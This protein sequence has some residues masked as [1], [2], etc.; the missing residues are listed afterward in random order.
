MTLYTNPFT[1]VPLYLLAYWIGSAL[2]GS[3]SGP[4]TEPPAFSWA[5][6]GEWLYGMT[7][8]ALAHG[9]PLAVGLIVLASG[10]AA[11][12]WTAVQLAWRAWVIVQWRR[13]GRRRRES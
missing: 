9:K 4:M 11:L 7:D 13:R 8:W 12:G 1:I 2:V 3:G 5:Q 10:L 6:A